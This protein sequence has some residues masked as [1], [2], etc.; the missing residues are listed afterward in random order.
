MRAG[1]PAVACEAMPAG[2]IG[3]MRRQPAGTA[4]APSCRC[5]G[6]VP[7]AS[8][9][10]SA[11]RRRP[12]ST[13]ARPASRGEEHAGAGL[14]VRLRLDLT[15]AGA[16]QAVNRERADRGPRPGPELG[17][18]PGRAVRYPA[19]RDR[20]PGHAA[21]AS[22]PEAVRR[23]PPGRKRCPRL[24]PGRGRGGHR[25]P[26]G[27]NLPAMNTPDPEAGTAPGEFSL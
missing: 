1:Q 8:L 17:S 13:R 3:R 18:P 21:P 25:K 12:A 22:R 11:T 6:Q 27:R 23:L 16:H 24:P 5:P 4:A 20:G 14:A 10:V 26:D 19:A 2:Q 7:A 9:E 15:L